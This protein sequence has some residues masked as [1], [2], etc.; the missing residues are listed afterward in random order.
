V[1]GAILLPI[2]PYQMLNKIGMILV[3]GT[4]ALI[5]PIEWPMNPDFLDFAIAAAHHVFEA[6]RSLRE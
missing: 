1:I 3:E 2:D 4:K 6:L 5:L